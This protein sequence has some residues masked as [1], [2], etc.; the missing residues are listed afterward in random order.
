MKINLEIFVSE[1]IS[2][3]MTLYYNITNSSFSLKFHIVQRIY[4]IKKEE[5]NEIEIENFVPKRN[6]VV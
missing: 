4:S 2:R 3:K 1:Q 5:I 6:H